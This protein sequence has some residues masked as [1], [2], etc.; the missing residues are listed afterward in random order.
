MKSSVYVFSKKTQPNYFLQRRDR[1][2]ATTFIWE[3]IACHG[4]LSKQHIIT[5]SSTITYKA[6]AFNGPNMDNKHSI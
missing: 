3:K 5:R 1:L 6:L 4:H 2:Q